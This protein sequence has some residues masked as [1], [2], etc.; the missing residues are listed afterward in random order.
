MVFRQLGR[1]PDFDQVLADE[2]EFSVED[3]RV[4]YMKIGSTLLFAFLVLPVIA[5]P[6]HAGVVYDDGPINGHTDSWVINFGFAV[7][8][9]F[10]VS[11]GASTLNSVSFGAWLIP[12]DI[13][14]SVEVTMTSAPF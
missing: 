9:S 14:S 10:T 4:L 3:G 2:S 13:L 6:I 5:L 8:D 11:S 7:A 1:A 12:G